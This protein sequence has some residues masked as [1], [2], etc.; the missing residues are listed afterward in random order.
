MKTYTNIIAIAAAFIIS[1]LPP[2]HAQEKIGDFIE[3]DKTVH[4]FGDI[5]LKIFT[6]IGE[7][8]RE[9]A[10]FILGGNSKDVLVFGF[11]RK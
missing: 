4:N 9:P 8:N 10:V 7:Q 3:I 2:L 5:L 11:I 6:A 1:F